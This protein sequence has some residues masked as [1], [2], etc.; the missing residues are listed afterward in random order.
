MEKLKIREILYTFINLSYKYWAF[1]CQCNLLVNILE[2][3][4]KWVC[5]NFDVAEPGT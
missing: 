5:F 3:K 4:S 2:I 1:C